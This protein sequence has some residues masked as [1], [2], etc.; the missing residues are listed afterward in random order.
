M[1]RTNK[2]KQTNFITKIYFF[3]QNKN[4]SKK[5]IIPK[6]AFFVY[7][8]LCMQLCGQFYL[9]INYTAGLKGTAQRNGK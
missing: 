2:N 3:L 5:L 4:F 1:E 6:V 8:V 7:Q 9:S